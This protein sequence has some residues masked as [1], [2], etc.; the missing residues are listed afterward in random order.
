MERIVATPQSEE[1]NQT[2]SDR[3][4]TSEVLPQ[5]SDYETVTEAKGDRPTSPQTISKS[6]PIEVS[7][8]EKGVA[9]SQH[10]RRFNSTAG[11]SVGRKRTYF[12]GFLRRRSSSVDAQSSRRSDAFTTIKHKL[13][14]F[15]KFIG[16]GFLVSVAYIDPG[17]SLNC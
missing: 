5:Q 16:P 14:K 8:D 6:I 10:S 9:S 2:S 11:E 1:R 17:M 3:D 4:L 7:Y 12:G 15:A 13:R